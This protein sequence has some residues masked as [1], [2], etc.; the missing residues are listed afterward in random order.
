MTIAHEAAT[1]TEHPASRVLPGRRRGGEGRAWT[2]ALALALGAVSCSTVGPYFTRAIAGRVRVVANL[3]DVDGNPT[4]QQRIEDADG[5]QVYLLGDGAVDSTRTVAGAY[6]FEHVGPG[7]YAAAVG[8]HGVSTDT[9]GEVT[10]SA[11]DVV[12]SDTLVLTTEDGMQSSPNPS[13]FM[14]SI[15]FSVPTTIDGTL[16][17]VT[18]G[19]G[20]KRTAYSGPLVAGAHIVTWDGRDDGGQYL[21]AGTYGVTVHAGAVRLADV[22]IRSP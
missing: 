19:G 22:I 3:Y 13:S 4:G 10:L 17:V 20:V 14:V 8:M 1:R 12:V 7:H 6:R 9:T 21:P 16:Q 2:L 18:L 15:R 11:R 5:V